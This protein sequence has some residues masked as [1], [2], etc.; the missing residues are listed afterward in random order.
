MGCSHTASRT[1]DRSATVSR[2][3]PRRIFATL[4]AALVSAP[5]FVGITVVAAPAE[6]GA[7]TRCAPV[8]NKYIGGTLIGQDG[9]DINAQVSMDVV[10][11]YGKGINML[12]CR[13]AAYSVTV[14][15]NKG[16]TGDG[17]PHTAATTRTWRVNRLPANA[18]KVWI[19]V[20]T[21]TG[22]D[23]VCPTC[24]GSID[25]HRYGFVN[26][27]AVPV[28]HG[29]LRLMAPL[30]CGIGRGSTGTIQGALTDKRGNKVSFGSIHAWSTAPDGSKPMQGWGQARRKLGYYVI[31]TLASGQEYVVWASYKC[32]SHKLYHIYVGSC[33]NVPVRFV[34]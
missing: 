19:E 28:N 26:R 10:D 17:A 13:T 33:K 30:H 3:T 31:P 12:G 34:V 21:R 32:V 20:W 24:D 23:R 22:V 6:A 16:L 18:V 29:A 15:M 8:S 7:T 27:R 25:T 2:P 5:V 4:I 1:T 11:K 14:W 9:R